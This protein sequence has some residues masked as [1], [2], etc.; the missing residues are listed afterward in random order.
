MEPCPNRCVRL[1]VYTG[2]DGTV[3]NRTASRTQTGPLRKKVPLGTAP[4]SSRVN[5]QNGSRQVRLEMRQWEIICR[6]YVIAEPPMRECMD[7]NGSVQSGS[8][9]SCKRE[10][11]PYLCGTVPYRTVPK[12]TC[13]RNRRR[14]C[15]S[16]F[17]LYILYKNMVYKS[18][19]VQNN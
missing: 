19:N 14:G 13:K 10:A 16:I 1:C 5:N 12:S 2:T 8:K 6:L 4:K 3:P 9:K 15:S 18:I 7:R 17:L 11:Y